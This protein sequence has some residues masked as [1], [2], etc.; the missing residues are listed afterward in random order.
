M[1]Q[2]TDAATLADAVEG[3]DAVIFTHGSSDGEG[4]NYGAVRSVL[5]TLGGRPYGSRS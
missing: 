1:G 2:L 3:V 4:V 5:Q